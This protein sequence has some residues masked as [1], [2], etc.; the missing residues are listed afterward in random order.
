[1][2]SYP[3]AVRTALVLLTLSVAFA[4]PAAADPSTATVRGDLERISLGNV[5]TYIYGID[6]RMIHPSP[7]MYENPIELTPGA[8]SLLI[9]FNAS[10]Y[11][12]LPARIDAKA[13]ASYV[14]RF[15]QTGQTRDELVSTVWIEDAA[16]GE[17]VVPKRQIWP[18]AKPA[19]TYVPPA[20]GA[21]AT[22]QGKA[23]TDRMGASFARAVDGLPTSIADVTRAV[24]LALAAGPR[25]L[26]ISFA[27]DRI[28]ANLPVMLDVKAGDRYVIGYEIDDSRF[29]S[30][31]APIFKFWVE[32]ATTN[33][34][35]VPETKVPV[36]VLKYD[37]D[38]KP[39]HGRRK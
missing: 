2:T 34:R 12:L 14:A 17:I 30:Q 33:K 28:I 19:I 7:P 11:A 39:A 37:M 20:S 8:H 25:A 4:S 15:E 10:K 13:G 3:H 35:V 26:L 36:R 18:D 32:N 9:G 23:T 29:S 31:A 24:P 6:G 22:I 38:V 5:G 1:M 27:S 21:T 16:S